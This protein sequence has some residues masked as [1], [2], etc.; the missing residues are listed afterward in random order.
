MLVRP[1]QQIVYDYLLHFVAKL[2]LKHVKSTVCVG[3]RVCVSCVVCVFIY[4]RN[5]DP[6]YFRFL[7]MLT[8]A[9]SDF[10]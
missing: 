3:A 4:V 10:W 7:L 6:A 5:D 8:P 9:A 1:P 2:Y